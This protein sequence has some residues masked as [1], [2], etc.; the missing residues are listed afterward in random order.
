MISF[1]KSSPRYRFSIFQ[2]IPQGDA[3][4]EHAVYGLYARKD[5]LHPDAKTGVLYPAGE[6]VAVLTTDGEGKAKIEDLYLG[7][8]NGGTGPFIGKCMGK[9]NLRLTAAGCF[10]LESI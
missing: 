1:T 7:E 4:L 5:I 6:Q 2:S 8:L 3:T 9:G 10:K